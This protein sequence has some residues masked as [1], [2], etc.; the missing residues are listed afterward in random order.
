[1]SKDR[2]ETLICL[3]TGMNMLKELRLTIGW[4]VKIHTCMYSVK[5]V[6]SSKHVEERIQAHL[7]NKGIFRLLGVSWRHL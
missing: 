4:L 6:P 1:M 3:W 5:V 2:I 7:L